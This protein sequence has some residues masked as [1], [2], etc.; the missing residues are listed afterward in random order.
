MIRTYYELG[1]TSDITVVFFTLYTDREV[2]VHKA[3]EMIGQSME[4]YSKEKLYGSTRD[5]DSVAAYHNFLNIFDPTIVH[6][7]RS[8]DLY[9]TVLGFDLTD[10]QY[11]IIS[12]FLSKKTNL[13]SRGWNDCNTIKLSNKIL[14]VHL[15]IDFWG[16]NK[17]M[18]Y[19][20]TQQSE[21][22]SRRMNEYSLPVITASTDMSKTY[23]RGNKIAIDYNIVNRI[24]D[25]DKKD[26]RHIVHLGLVGPDGFLITNWGLTE[27]YFPDGSAKYK[28]VKLTRLYS[29]MIYKKTLILYDGDKGKDTILSKII[30]KQ[31]GFSGV[32]L[33][34]IHQFSPDRSTNTPSMR[35]GGY[36][37]YLVINFIPD[38]EWKNIRIEHSLTAH[39]YRFRSN[40]KVAGFQRSFNNGDT[41]VGLYPILVKD[42]QVDTKM[43]D[44][45]IDVIGDRNNPDKVKTYLDYIQSAVF[46]LYN[47]NN[48]GDILSS[49]FNKAAASKDAEKYA[50]LRGYKQ[51]YRTLLKDKK[52]IT[53]YLD[54]IDL[55]KSKPIPSIKVD[56]RL[57]IK[58]KRFGFWLKTTTI[59]R[60]LHKNIDR[61]VKL[62]PYINL[63]FKYQGSFMFLRYDIKRFLDSKNNVIDLDF[64]KVKGAMYYDKTQN[65]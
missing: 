18:S 60:V 33:V 51:M 62:E 43:L 39:T 3:K 17:N 32:E 45:T 48:E 9:E 29:F 53:T 46:N 41:F 50:I 7:R 24:W 27:H 6:Q 28:W 14:P 30:E 19:V 10:K 1:C 35:I 15:I 40:G 64:D 63:N 26:C 4:N 56:R 31:S 49:W 38:K 54:T 22:F 36:K 2:T 20:L 57:D 52:E 37:K 21:D 65:R 8:D 11:N 5:L 47:I 16:H 13:L 58:P 12:N 55:S 42:N 44:L 61:Q 34:I 23:K 59:D 25:I